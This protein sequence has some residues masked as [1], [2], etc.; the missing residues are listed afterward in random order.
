MQKQIDPQKYK[1][2]QNY[3]KNCFR[4]LNNLF[5]T[6]KHI[7]QILRKSKPTAAMPS[8]IKINGKAITANKTIC[9]EMNEPFVKIGEKSGNITTSTNDIG[10][11]KF[12]G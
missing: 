2:K 3:F 6:W 7:N 11:I 4:E 5:D 12:F 9:N 1:A 8:T 10:Y